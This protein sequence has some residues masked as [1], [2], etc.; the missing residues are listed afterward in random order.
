MVLDFVQRKIPVVPEGGTCVVDARDVAAAM[1]TAAERA[2][3]ASRYIVG[4]QF[5]SLEQL[6]Q[7]LEA[8]TGIAAP[9]LHLP[10]FMVLAFAFLEELRVRFTGGPLLVSRAAVK[11]MRGNLSASSARAER[12]LGAT[13][14]PLSET[15]ADTLRW[16]EQHGRI[17]ASQLPAAARAP[18]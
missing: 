13:F 18:A 11:L 12:E 4:G 8:Q 17:A 9:R 7:A 15:L 10:F 3:H 2:P 14:R 5:R 6:L 16:Y 1:L